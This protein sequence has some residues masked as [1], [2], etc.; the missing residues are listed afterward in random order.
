[1]KSEPALAKPLHPRLPYPLAAVV[2]GARHEQA[3]TLEDILSRRT[4][5]LILDARAAIEA[6]PAAAALL[7]RELGRD[8]A[9]AK[10]QVQEFTR[11]AEGYLN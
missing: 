2:W 10:N 7:A 1:M 5:A 3:R 9:W 4:R 11:L 8:E 6:A